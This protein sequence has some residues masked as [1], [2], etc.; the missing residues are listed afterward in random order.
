MNDS[1]E[2][3][4]YYVFNN[5]TSFHYLCIVK[6]FHRGINTQ[7]I[8]HIETKELLSVIFFVIAIVKMAEIRRR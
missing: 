4:G 6:F 1:V 5:F 8:Q 7:R 3:L 2:L